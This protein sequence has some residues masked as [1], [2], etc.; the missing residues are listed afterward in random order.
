MQ[1]IDR[2][3]KLR[4]VNHA[5]R[6]GSAPNPNLLYTAADALHRLPVVRLVPLL[7]QIDLMTCLVSRRVR[8]GS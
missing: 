4:D 6:P 2:V 8:E 7:Y 3:S 1:D 5:E